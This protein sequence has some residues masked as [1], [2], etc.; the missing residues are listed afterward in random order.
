M[1]I[2]EELEK[3]GN[4]LFRYRSFLPLAILLIGAAVLVHTS[5]SNSSSEECSSYFEVSC[6][7]ISLLGLAIRI[8]AVGH[9]PSNTSGRN[10]A[11]GQVAD[12]LNTKGIYSTVRHPLY[13]G[14]FLMWLGIALLTLNT[15]FIVSFVL[16]YWIYYE[17]IMFAEEQ[18]LE[19]KFGADYRKWADRVPIFVPRFSQFQRP[20][21]RFSLRKILKKEKNGLFATFLIFALFDIIYETASGHDHFNTIFLVG[22]GLTLLMYAVLK[23]LKYRTSI[24]EERR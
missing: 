4:W 16:C 18:F 3:Q 2:K 17:R 8:Y 19:R 22:T 5:I 7:I 20:E 11:V 10:T 6:L 1:A 24:L 15:W 23:L 9:S 14:N 13:L 12:V 21:T